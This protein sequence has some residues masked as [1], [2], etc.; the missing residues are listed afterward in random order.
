MLGDRFNIIAYIESYLHFG[1]AYKFGCTPIIY[2]SVY[3]YAHACVPLDEGRFGSG[4]I[5]VT[6]SKLTGLTALS[7]RVCSNLGW[8]KDI[9]IQLSITVVHH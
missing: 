3:A 2:M 9:F 8:G 1:P 6:G 5:S 4:A 7:N